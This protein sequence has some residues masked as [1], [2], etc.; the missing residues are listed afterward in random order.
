MTGHEA[1][2]LDILLRWLL[3]L[4]PPVDTV[5]AR[6]A[7]L[8]LAHQAHAAQRSAPTEAIIAKAWKQLNLEGHCP[9]C[10]IKL[11]RCS[12]GCDPFRGGEKHGVRG[13]IF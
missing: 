6:D 11:P 7:A 1:K 3:E 8:Y 13:T 4:D 10:H 5:A 12:C 9:V 2:A